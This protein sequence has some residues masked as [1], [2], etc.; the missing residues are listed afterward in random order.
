M[1][2][3]VFTKGMKSIA[4]FNIFIFLYPV[5]IVLRY[6]LFGT[7]GGILELIFPLV[8]IYSGLWATSFICRKEYYFT[9]RL[10]SFVTVVIP[11]IISSII[12]SDLGLGRSLLGA[13]AVGIFYIIGSNNYTK[14]YQDIFNSKMLFFSVFMLAINMIMTSSFDSLKPMRNVVFIFILLFIPLTMLI[15]S[16]E[17]IDEVFKFRGVEIPEV[18]K[19]IRKENL[20]SIILLYAVMLVIFNIKDLLAAILQ[21]ILMIYIKVS[22]FIFY[23]LSKLFIQSGSG[24][25]K[26]DSQPLPLTPGPERSN[27]LLDY[28]FVA[29]TAVLI[30]FAAYKLL[31]RLV[32]AISGLIAYIK[33]KLSK[34]IRLKENVYDDS[35]CVEIVE[36]TKQIVENKVKKK[37][38]NL[39]A[40]LKK[41]TDPAKRIR[42]MYQ[43]ILKDLGEKGI[44]VASSDTTGQVIEKAAGLENVKEEIEN[45]TS[46]YERVRYGEEIPQA[47][48]LKSMEEGYRKILGKRKH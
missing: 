24:S 39:F 43:I 38:V 8:S 22:I 40:I 27:N 21:F 4:L 36:I 33:A 11:V 10:L 35:E 44:T 14:Q 3:R 6:F 23:L 42:L 29:V 7:M 2:G 19:S 1:M 9:T 34:V 46:I 18:Q 41:A 47:E 5:F 17:N 32:K 48:L 26:G 12:F 16:Q 37:R 20:K 30:I 28:L 45:I 15:K 25:S 31:P 13:S